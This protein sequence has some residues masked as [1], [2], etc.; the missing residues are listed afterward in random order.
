[1][2]AFI[3][4]SGVSSLT[5]APVQR[6]SS[7]SSLRRPNA[8]AA[9][10]TRQPTMVAYPYTGSGYGGAGVPYGNDP[11]GQIFKKTDTEDIVVTAASVPVFQTLASLL[12][13]TGL[14]YDLQKAGP[15]TVFAPTDDAFAALLGP[16]G[17][18]TL[19]ALLRPENIDELRKVLL[20]HVVP[21]AITSDAIVTSGGKVVG[22]SLSGDTITVMAYNRNISAGSASV[23]RKDIPCTNGIIHC[24]NSV[25]I[26]ASY[27]TPPIRPEPK[28]YPNSIVT[29][30]YG[31]LLTPRQA[32]GIDATPEGAGSIETFYP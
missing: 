10:T 9:T 7:V 30:L 22:T 27:K 20:Y 31:K 23:I 32:L 4:A 3:P 16:H 18:S 5:G 17:F 14:D 12:V 6:A 11:V 8:A 1:M 2:H 13:K 21:G 24:I 29:D 28:Q 26:P 25:L 19:G 15:F